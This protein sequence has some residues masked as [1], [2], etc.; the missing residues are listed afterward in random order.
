M[1]LLIVSFVFVFVF[2]MGCQ[3]G[4]QKADLILKNGVFFT[5]NAL[6]PKVQAVAIR[7]DRIVAVGK[8]EEA[9][10]F[11]GEMTR[12]IDLGGLFGCPG[13]NDAHLHFLSG[14]K[15]MQEVDLTGASSVREIQRRVLKKL[16]K[17]PPGSWVTGRGWDQTLL[18]GKE[19]PTRR[20]L[21]VIAPDVPVC[22]SRVC[23]HAALVNSKALRIAGITADTPN[24]PAGEI[25]RDPVTGQPTGILKEEAMTLV[26]QYIPPLSEEAVEM[27]VERALF[28]AKRFGVTSVQDNTSARMLEVYQKL[29]DEGRLTCRISEWPP[30]REDLKEYKRLRQKY[31]GTMI[32][33]GLLKGF[34]DGS[35]GSR[36]AA[37]A[38]PYLDDP[39]TRGIPQMTQEELNRL[40]LGA[41]KEGFQVG[42]HAIGDEGNRMVL[43]A[44]A[45]ARQVNGGRDSRH[46]IEHAQVLKEADLSRFDELGVVASM[47][48]TH[49]IS[50]MR[51]AEERIGTQRCRYAYA[52]RSLKDR[53][54]VLAF[55][56]DWPVE[57]LNPM[58]GLYAAVTRRDT[59]GYPSGGWF[60]RERVTI[61]EAIEAYTLGSAYAEF[62]DEEKGSLEP[63]KL[64]D[65]VILD[66]NLLEGSPEEIL[67][68]K[69][70]YNILGG[71]IVYQREE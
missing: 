11:L 36:T 3:Q 70:I 35:M 16:S 48:P 64:A 26:F 68:T 53:G 29:L 67:K 25:M 9:D 41:D 59:L 14:G 2:L 56:T 60:P 15:S 57:P 5:G 71:K 4:S 28:E 13:F 43:D 18:P 31:K 44:Y 10:R 63:D 39:T 8:N 40:V 21:D 58:L 33:F 24:P 66:R 55:G 30:L 54:A 65:I 19:W 38:E 50:D 51:W 34:A 17:L 69:V 47:Q 62:M 12:V 32:R 46:R 42:V 7:G 22:L 45:L 6:Q 52:W 37:F 49:C 27:A 20:I 23:G 61:E 1:L